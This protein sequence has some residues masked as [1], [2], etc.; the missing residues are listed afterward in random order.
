MGSAP[1]L[2]HRRETLRD[3][4]SLQLPVIPLANRGV[5]HFVA[6]VERGGVAVLALGGAGDTLVVPAPAVAPTIP[7]KRQHPEGALAGVEVLVKLVELR[8]DNRVRLKGNFFP[9]A[10]R[11]FH[12]QEFVSL[13]LNHDHVS[14]SVVAV[15]GHVSAL[16]TLV[17]MH[18][19]GG[20]GHGER[21]DR[22]AVAPYGIGIQDQFADV[23]DEV[24]LE[25]PV[26][27]MLAF[28]AVEVLHGMRVTVLEDKRVV[29]DEVKIVI[30]VDDVRHVGAEEKPARLVGRAVEFLVPGVE[31]DRE[32]RPLFPLHG[33]FGLSLLPD[34]A[35]APPLHRVH[36]GVI[37]M[38][39]GSE[40]PLGRDLDDLEV[41]LFLVAH[42]RVGAL[43]PAPL[44]VSQGES[45]EVFEGAAFI[46]G[47][48]LAFDEILIG[49]FN[50]PVV[51]IC[52]HPKNLPFFIF[53][54]REWTSCYRF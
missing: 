36:D 7:T 29:K 33:L 11:S 41:A 17:D 16:W 2:I 20:T 8:R 9:L 45:G 6:D 32:Q 46:K 18:A 26:L 22:V 52:R 34:H 28:V 53:I 23:G 40:L 48:A 25:Y 12:P 1:P 27:P 50:V 10:V 35:G 37:R 38:A 24:G 5:F 39:L 47:D 43:A 30:E 14:T 21:H 3:A 13:S 44:P 54:P 51:E 42:A 31:R 15:G 19:D 49:A 4:V